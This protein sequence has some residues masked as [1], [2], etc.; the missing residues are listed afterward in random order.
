MSARLA[1]L[2]EREA[3]NL[4]VVGSS[5]TVGTYFIDFGKLSLQNTFQHTPC[6]WERRSVCTSV[7]TK[8]LLCRAKMKKGMHRTSQQRWR[9]VR[10]IHFSPWV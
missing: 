3:L 8:R 9:H 1:Q 4:V 6:L 5:P 10:L 7:C 2:V